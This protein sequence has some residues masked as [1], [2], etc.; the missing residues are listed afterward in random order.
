MIT[1]EEALR[2]LDAVA[3]ELI[4]LRA[5]LAEGWTERPSENLTQVFLMK[6]GGWKDTRSPE[7]IIAEI[8]AART[9][10]QRAESLDPE[11]SAG[12]PVIWD[13]HQR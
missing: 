5:A 9:V 4:A 1:R 8:Y 7:E 10:S 6:C 2:R 11:P 12:Q 3:H 13:A